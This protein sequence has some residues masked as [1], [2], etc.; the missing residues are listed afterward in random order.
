MFGKGTTKG[1]NKR[2]QTAN[3]WRGKGEE[4]TM[5]FLRWRKGLM[6]ILLG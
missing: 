6:E 3:V 5:R 1:N 2:L 4:A